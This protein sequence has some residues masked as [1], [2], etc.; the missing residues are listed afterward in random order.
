MLVSSFWSVTERVRLS[1]WQCLRLDGTLSF[2]DRLASDEEVWLGF[3]MFQGMACTRD[4][5]ALSLCAE[6]EVQSGRV[7]GYVWFPVILSVCYNRAIVDVLS[8]SLFAGAICHAVCQILSVHQ[9]DSNELYNRHVQSLHQKS[10]RRYRW[11][12]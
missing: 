3:G 10:H 6:T 1:I 7:R 5:S 9:P 11:T 4:M 2:D 8:P 12:S